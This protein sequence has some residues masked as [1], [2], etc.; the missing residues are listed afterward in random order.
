M[1][2]LII[3]YLHLLMF[4]FPINFS[5][6][7]LFFINLL[8]DYIAFRLSKYLNFLFFQY[9]KVLKFIMDRFNYRRQI[10]IIYISKLIFIYYNNK[11]YIY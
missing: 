7:S 5:L 4:L 8:Y 6:L 2:N 11:I 9:I 3:I 1:H 10:N